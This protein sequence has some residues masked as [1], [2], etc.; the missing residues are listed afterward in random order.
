MKNHIIGLR[1]IDIWSNYNSLYFKNSETIKDPAYFKQ[2]KRTILN[3]T[4]LSAERRAKNIL[5]NI[6]GGNTILIHMKMTGHLLYGHF[7]YIK[8]NKKDPWEAIEPESLKDPFNKR[9]RFVITFNNNRHLALSDTR[10]FA[11]IT[12]VNSEIIHQS[13]HHRAY[14]KTNERCEKK[15][16]DGTIKRIVVGGRATH[17]CDKHQTIL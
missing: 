10:R 1:I 9:I 13:K 8:S 17:Y 2:F 5:I 11:K 7:K 6:S 14:Q 16:C 3:K 12:V 4:I 15:G